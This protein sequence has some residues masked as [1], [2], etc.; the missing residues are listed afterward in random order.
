MAS[1][2]TFRRLAGSIG[3]AVSLSLSGL[4]TI[5]PASA[6]DITFPVVLEVEAPEPEVGE[7]A[8]ISSAAPSHDGE[9]LIYV[10]TEYE[11]ILLMQPGGPD[12]YDRRAVRS[13]LTAKNSQTDEVKT[14]TLDG[15]AGSIT[16]T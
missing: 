13:V 14:L 5:S 10:V 15:P 12:Y 7:F 6:Q 11:P 1:A 3:V 8:E 2:I 4:G 9:W 16:S